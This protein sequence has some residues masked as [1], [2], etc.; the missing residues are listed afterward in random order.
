LSEIKCS[1]EISLYLLLI[2]TMIKLN[3]N[4]YKMLEIVIF[5]YRTIPFYNIF[6][7]IFLLINYQHSK[8]NPLLITFSE[9]KV[10]DEGLRALAAGLEI[11]RGLQTLGITFS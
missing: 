8:L 6:T 5:S 1:S 4:F 7:K 3:Y 2:K 10:T 11:H 9:T